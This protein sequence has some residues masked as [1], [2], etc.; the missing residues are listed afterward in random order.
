MTKLQEQRQ[1]EYRQQIAR[2]KRQYRRMKD[3]GY[4]FPGG[5][6]PFI[7]RTIPDH[8]TKRD[9]DRL[10]AITA[11]HFYR[12]A[13]YLDPMTGEVI[14]GHQRRDAERKASAQRAAATR[15][16]NKQ[17]D[18]D[19]ISQ[20]FELQPP[21]PPPP[22]SDQALVQFLREASNLVEFG[23]WIRDQAKG[24]FEGGD[25]RQFVY[26]RIDEIANS[27]RGLTYSQKFVF[28]QQLAKII[29]SF[30]YVYQT[31]LLAENTVNTF[32]SASAEFKSLISEIRQAL[33]IAIRS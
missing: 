10:R 6:P 28:Q 8:V 3:R 24:R 30:V 11:A 1:R 26:D 23:G 19:W 31:A 18:I 29:E 22:P 12:Y 17:A 25:Y 9:V 2:L 27:Y 13:R 4:S 5:R 16:M 7:P 14:T 32:N 15:K 21:T 20:R 33:L